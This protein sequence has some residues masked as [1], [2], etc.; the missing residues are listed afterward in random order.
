MQERMHNPRQPSERERVDHEMMHLSSAVGAS[1]S[2]TEGG[3]SW[4]F[5]KR[6]RMIEKVPEIHLYCMFM[7]DEK[8]DIRWERV[9]SRSC[10]QHGAEEVDGIMDLSNAGGMAS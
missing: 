2:S 9:S 10:V 7:D 1:I 5:A 4:T 3:E 6:L 8:K